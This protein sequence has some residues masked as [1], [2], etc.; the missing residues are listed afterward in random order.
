[1][2]TTQPPYVINTSSG[3]A[4]RHPYEEQNMT[5][6]QEADPH[7]ADLRPPPRPRWVIWLAIVIVAAVLIFLGAHLLM[8]GHGPIQHMPGTNHGLPVPVIGNGV[9]N[10]IGGGAT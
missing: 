6:R 10:S 9:R 7:D 1:M 8:G 5:E 2:A 3:R 4:R